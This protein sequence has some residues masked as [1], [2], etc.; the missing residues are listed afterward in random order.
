M[1]IL[2][3]KAQAL[4]SSLFNRQLHLLVQF[5]WVPEKWLRSE[6]MDLAI[7]GTPSP[8]LLLTLA[9]LILLPSIT[10]SLTSTIR[11]TCSSMIPPMANS[12]VQ[13]RL[14]REN[15]PQIIPNIMR[16]LLTLTSFHPRSYEEGQGPRK[17]YFIIY[18]D[19]VH[20]IYPEK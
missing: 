3:F 11:S 13:L 2:K 5:Q 8:G 20:C 18:I 12:M 19:K 6:K 17:P 15:L 4:C 16:I 14:R 9:K 10:P 1:Q 7:L